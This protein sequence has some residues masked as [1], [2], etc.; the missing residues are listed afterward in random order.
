M[1]KGAQTRTAILD[2]ATDLSSAVGLEALSIGAL[3]KRTGMSKS[4]LYAHFASK[5][6]L[7]IQ[8]LD[9]LADRARRQVYVPAVR[10]PRGVPRVRAFF[11]NWL[12]WVTDAFPGGCPITA[13]SVEFDDRD[14]PVRDRLAELCEDRRESLARAARVAVE[15]GHFRADLADEQFAF[16]VLGVLAA[17]HHYARLLR[18]PEAKKRAQGAFETILREAQANAP[19]PCAVARA[20]PTPPQ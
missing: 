3:A 20:E 9:A 14:G 15:A 12:V 13:A 16:D 7:Q 5:E 10:A 2:H 1:S 8:V 11:A 17:Y 4:G 6:D 18:R 19:T